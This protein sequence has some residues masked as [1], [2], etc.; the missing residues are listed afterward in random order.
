MKG[1]VGISGHEKEREQEDPPHP[2]IFVLLKTVALFVI[3]NNYEKITHYRAT[4]LLGYAGLSVWKEAA[5]LPVILSSLVTFQSQLLAVG[6]AT[7]SSVS[8][9]TSDLRQYDATTL[10]W[11]VINR[12]D[13][14]AL[15]QFFLTTHSWCVVGTRGTHKDC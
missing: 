13:S 12:S 5:P 3:P 8:D 6:G 11:K 10:S 15:Q 1:D 4:K 7:S 2:Y 9:S 14:I